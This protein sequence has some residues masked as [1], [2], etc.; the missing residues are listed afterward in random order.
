MKNKSR[1]R[2]PTLTAMPEPVI[3][4]RYQ[5]EIDMSTQRLERRYRKAQRA[6]EAAEKRAARAWADVVKNARGAKRRHSD[7]QALVEERRAELREIERLMMPA[8]HTSRDGRRRHV[9]HESGAITVPLGATTGQRPRQ[10][11]PRVFPV[12]VEETAR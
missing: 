5:T 12:H 3:S 9:R 1:H 6:L 2:V 7:L 8:D 11:S 4:E 10:T